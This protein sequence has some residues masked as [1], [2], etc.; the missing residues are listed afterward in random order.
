[1]Y[2]ATTYMHKH[3]LLIRAKTQFRIND[4][5]KQHWHA[6]DR[7]DKYTGLICFIHLRCL[8]IYLYHPGT[9]GSAIFLFSI[10]IILAELIFEFENV[11]SSLL[12]IMFVVNNENSTSHIHLD[13]RVALLSAQLISSEF[14]I[15]NINKN[16]KF[17][18]FLH[19]KTCI[20][21]LDKLL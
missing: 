4:A 12:L 9:A 20:R 5:D 7:I 14:P 11:K 13:I 2:G 15:L 21:R 10:Q 1:M 3:I 6:I 19:R 8:F 16:R 17:A 18:Y